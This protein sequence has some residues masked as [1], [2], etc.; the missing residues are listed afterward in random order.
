M[1]KCFEASRS[2]EGGRKCPVEGSRP[3]SLHFY[4][5]P[6]DGQNPCILTVSRDLIEEGKKVQKKSFYV[7]HLFEKSRFENRGRSTAQITAFLGVIVN[8]S[9]GS[10]ANHRLPGPRHSAHIGQQRTCNHL[11]P[12]GALGRPTLRGLESITTT[13]QG[14]TGDLTPVSYTHLTLPTNC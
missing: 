12:A 6:C 13:K 8:A 4:R 3:D 14:V 7:G 10:I 11:S 2:S 1:K 9:S 5:V